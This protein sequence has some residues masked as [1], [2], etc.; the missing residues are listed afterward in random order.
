MQSVNTT[1]TE[2]TRVEKYR[3]LRESIGTQAEVAAMLGIARSALHRR[4]AGKRRI[5]DE[6]MFAMRYL[7]EREAK[8]NPAPKPP[9]PE[10][11]DDK[12]TPE[13]LANYAAFVEDLIASHSMFSV[14]RDSRLIAALDP[15]RTIWSIQGC[16][17]VALLARRYGVQIRETFSRHFA[18]ATFEIS[19]L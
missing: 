11:H 18:G 2:L 17:N 8:P 1:K 15:E 10:L 14:F 6:V 16:Q 3:Q 12:P 5:T 13:D 7:H 4:E 9:Q 19:K